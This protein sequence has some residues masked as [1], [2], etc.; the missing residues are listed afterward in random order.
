MDDG[1][2]NNKRKIFLTV[3]QQKMEK[4]EE[5]STLEQVLLLFKRTAGFCGNYI[6]VIPK[7][8][9]KKIL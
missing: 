8:W 9:G 7:G 6:L 1:Q 2:T 5:Y 4:M 3:G